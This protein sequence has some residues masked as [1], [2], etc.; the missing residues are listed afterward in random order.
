VYGARARFT[1]RER[2]TDI[3]RAFVR[4]SV[5]IPNTAAADTVF[6]KP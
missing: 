2:W 3:V 1:N 5:A 4:N 6:Y